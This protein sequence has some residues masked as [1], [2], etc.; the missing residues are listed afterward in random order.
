KPD[1]TLDNVRVVYYPTLNVSGIQC[2]APSNSTSWNF[3]DAKGPLG[4]T[5][6]NGMSDP[7]YTPNGM[8]YKISAGDPWLQGP[9]IKDVI[10]EN[11]RYV[12]VV[13]ASQTDQCGQIY[14]KKV[15][16]SN[17]IEAQH[18]WFDVNPDGSTRT[19]YVDMKSN[20]LWSG[21]IK[22]LRLDPAC[23]PVAGKGN[24]VRIDLIALTNTVDTPTDTPTNTP[25]DTPDAPTD[26]PDAPTDVP[27]DTPTGTS[28]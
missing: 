6:E 13:M 7:Q 24:A 11:Y 20:N 10:A 5:I 2:Y 4:W 12:K 21:A 16:Q 18:V 14:F 15:G 9:G 27:T 19:Y 8:W 17:Y 3:G 1:Y 22:Q 23:V 25:T 28:T 26:T